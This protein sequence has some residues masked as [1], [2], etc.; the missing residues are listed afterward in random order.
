MATVTSIAATLAAPYLESFTQDSWFAFVKEWRAFRAKGGK[1]K[2]LSLISAHSLTGIKRRLQIIG[3]EPPFGVQMNDD[4]RIGQISAVFGPRDEAEVLSILYSDRMTE[5]GPADVSVDAVAEYITRWDEKLELISMDLRPKMTTIVKAF[6]SGLQPLS[7]RR[8]ARAK[9]FESL[10]QTQSNVLLEADRLSRLRQAAAA[11]FGLYAT[12]RKAHSSPSIKRPDRRWKAPNHDSAARSMDNKRKRHDLGYMNTHHSDNAPG[13][14]QITRQRSHIVCHHCGQMGH[15]KSECRQLRHSKFDPSR[16]NRDS[17][18]GMSRRAAHTNPSPGAI[19][20]RNSARPFNKR[21]G[22]KPRRE[23]SLRETTS[24]KVQAAA[25]CLTASLSDWKAD[26]GS[27]EDEAYIHLIRHSGHHVLPHVDVTIVTPQ[28][29]HWQ[30]SALLD[31]GATHSVISPEL[32]TTLLSKG[33]IKRQT[34]R[35][36]HMASGSEVEITSELM[37]VIRLNPCSTLTKTME[38][39]VPVLILPPTVSGQSATENFILSYPTL[40]SMGLLH[41]LQE[42]TSQLTSSDVLLQDNYDSDVDA[43]P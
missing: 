5:C 32:A 29:D 34:S 38:T 41:L 30:L 14:R 27:S 42:T 3:K 11:E 9:E 36:L 1:G 40:S 20:A 33:Y 6:T 37:L 39:T 21:S 24:P 15:I 26:D 17:A 8:Y 7:L 18:T 28:G 12:I 23:S 10:E 13:D 16:D 43:P 19:S 35:T 25:N 4:D 2:L 31:S 22:W